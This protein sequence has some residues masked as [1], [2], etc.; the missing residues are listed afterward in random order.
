MYI[1]FGQEIRISDLSNRITS[2]I[3]RAG[4]GYVWVPTDFAHLGT[5]DAI[6][7]ALQRMVS[8]GMLRRIDRGLY[9]RPALNRLTQRQSTADYQAVVDAIA[10]RDQLRILVDGMTAAN[11]LG[12][13][14][15]VPARVTVYTDTRR[16]PIKLDNLLIDFKQAAPSRLCWAGRPAMRVVQALQWLKD[17]LAGD[18]DRI[19]SR[20]ALLLK[21]PQH[22]EA[23]RHDLQ[24]GFA[25]LP[26]WMQKFMRTLPDF[27]PAPSAADQNSPQRDVTTG[28]RAAGG[29]T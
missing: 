16:R 15:A 6:D 21:D 1:V 27:D 4:P 18:G 19:R 26:G 24:Q 8:G 10:R 23:I 17:T 29:P 13:S 20:I 5:R 9:D 11:D 14:D 25:A 28:G 2:M 3:D 7:K 12:L 22:G